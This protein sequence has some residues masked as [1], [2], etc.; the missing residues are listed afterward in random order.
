MIAAVVLA[1]GGSTRLGR[2]KQVLPLAGRP[3]LAHVLEAAAASPVDEVVVV[4]GHAARQVLTALSTGLA[5]RPSGSPAVR[6]ALNPWWSLG[7]ST[8]LRAGL[9]AAS[10]DAEACVVLLGDQP[11]VRREAIAR[12]VEAWREGAGPVVQASYSGRPAHPTLVAR[13]VW[14]HLDE[15]R[16]D[17]G[18]RAILSLHPEWR[19]LVE[20]GGDPPGDI[21]TE[22]DYA[23]VRRELERI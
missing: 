14:P 7:Q 23:R 4:L 1:A 21:D 5:D 10:P 18:A 20:V 9:L 22:A 13:P 3:V 8:S 12:V 16:G 11:G 6:F 15:V 2:P 19:H 17:E